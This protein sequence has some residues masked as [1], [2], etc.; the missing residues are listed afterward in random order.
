METQNKNVAPIPDIYKETLVEEFAGGILKK[1]GEPTDNGLVA[2]LYFPPG[3]I[4]GMGNTV[5]VV[6]ASGAGAGAKTLVRLQELSGN[7][8]FCLTCRLDDSGLS[9]YWGA[10]NPYPVTYTDTGLTELLQDVHKPIQEDRAQ[11][12]HL[13]AA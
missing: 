1:Y 9:V 12:V 13:S 11:S 8:P 7:D 2:D 4:K 10:E 3:T 5:L 6:E